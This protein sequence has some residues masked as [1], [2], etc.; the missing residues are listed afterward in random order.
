MKKNKRMLLTIGQVTL[1]VAFTGLL[2]VGTTESLKPVTVYKLAQN[3]PEN[4]QIGNSDLVAVDIPKSALTKKM[5]TS[6][7]DVKE[8]VGKKFAGSKLY[9][10]SYAL[11][12][13]FVESD[14]VDPFTTEDLTG[15]RKVS[16]PATYVNTLG[17]NLAY[18]DKVDLIYVGKEETTP[19]NSAESPK[20]F[21]YAKTFLEGALVFSVTTEDGYAFTD[22][23]TD[24][25]STTTTVDE[26]SDEATTTTTEEDYGD[27]ATVTLAVTAAQAEEI[28]SRLNS[29]VIQIAGRFDESTDQ[30]TTGYVIGEFTKVLT[31]PG[32]AETNE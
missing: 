11:A 26:E 25:I 8:I 28:I 23:S 17:G 22:H 16:I 32:L 4:S 15:L 14:E 1:A 13:M 7:E 30:D 24:I 2:W 5:I 27:I 6:T 19:T 20:E 3:I 12:D 31:G 18:G 29:G 21:T 9:K 10:D